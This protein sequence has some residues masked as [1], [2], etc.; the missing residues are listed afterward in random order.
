MIGSLLMASRT[1]LGF[2]FFTSGMSACVV[3]HPVKMRRKEPT[4]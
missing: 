2:F 4:P 3:P 1:V